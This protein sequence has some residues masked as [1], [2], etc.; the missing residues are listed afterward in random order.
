MKCAM[1]TAAA[2]LA[3]HATPGIAEED[4]INRDCNRF[5][6]SVVPP[7]T[8]GSLTPDVLAKFRQKFAP[9][10]E[11]ARQECEFRKQMQI[12]ANAASDAANKEEAKIRAQR[13]REYEAQRPAREAA[14]RE[15]AVEQERIAG[16]RERE[17]IADERERGRIAGERERERIANLP[18]TRLLDGY[19]FFAHVKWCHDV[20]DGYAYKFINVVELERAEMAIKAIVAQSTKENASIN[21]DDVWKQALASIAGHLRQRDTA[22]GLDQVCQHSLQELFKISPTPVYSIAK[23]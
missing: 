9:K 2:V 20:R 14:E 12:E 6:S 11:A 8:P 22:N 19:R 13:Q 16:E 10:I 5:G 15:A 23:P 3:T 21:T 7:I 17:R 1:I 4:W 18:F